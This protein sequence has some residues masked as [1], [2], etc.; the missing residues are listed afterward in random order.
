ML[1]QLFA[2]I[3]SKVYHDDAREFSHLVDGVA[4]GTIDDASEIIERLTAL[5]KTPEELERAVE[6]QRRR[7]ELRELLD[8]RPALEKERDDLTARVEKEN[9]IL[10]RATQQH[11]ERTLPLENRLEELGAQLAK[12]ARA[13]DELRRESPDTD[14][15]A[16]VERAKAGNVQTVAKMRAVDL[17]L[18]GI[19]S[20]IVDARRE[21]REAESEI[22][23][24]WRVSKK[25]DKIKARIASLE[26]EAK[27]ARDELDA[28]KRQAERGAENLE[29]TL[30][31]L[32]AS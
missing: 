7:A 8:R 13:S 18:D 16:A 5:R 20:K 4:C 21:L 27:Q 23:D 14:A 26:S 6:V 17:R 24:A 12:C 10:E 2:A 22:P 19:K 28:L 32:E 1:R 29:A 15:S 9:A 3:K 30:A 11:R 25:P 31:E